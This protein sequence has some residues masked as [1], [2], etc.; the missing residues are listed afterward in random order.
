MPSRSRRRGPSPTSSSR[1]DY[2]LFADSSKIRR[3]GFHDY[4]ETPAMFFSLFE[5]LRRE[6]VIP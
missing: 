4:V 6:R 1:G 2:D 5:Q 3:H